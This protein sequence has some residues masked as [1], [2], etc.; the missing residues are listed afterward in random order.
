M[1]TYIDTYRE[2]NKLHLNIPKKHIAS[3]LSMKPET[4]ARTFKKLEEEGLIKKINHKTYEIL[5]KLT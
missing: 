4:L 1:L 5:Q 2:G 3:Y